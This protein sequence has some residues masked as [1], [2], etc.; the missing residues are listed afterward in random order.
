MAEWEPLAV[1]GMRS[2]REEA[3][4]RQL[5]RDKAGESVKGWGWI[6]RR[7]IIWMHHAKQYRRDHP[8]AK[9]LH[10]VIP[11]VARNARDPETGELIRRPRRAVSAAGRPGSGAL[12]SAET[13]RAAFREACVNEANIVSAELPPVPPLARPPPKGGTPSWL[14]DPDDV[15]L[16][17][18]GHITARW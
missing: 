5:K 8:E 4:A 15:W 6:A 7:N 13:I 9:W 10:E 16:G 17:V 1:A 18:L 14:H 11:D 2:R 12:Y 3:N